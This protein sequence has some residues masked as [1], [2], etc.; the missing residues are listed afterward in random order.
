MTYKESLDTAFRYAD[1]E[2]SDFDYPD[3]FH[4]LANE[5]QMLIATQGDKILRECEVSTSSTASGPPSP[6][7]EGNGFEL[8]LPEDLYEIR[9]IVDQNGRP[10]EY[11]VYERGIAIVPKLGSYKVIYYALPEII[12]ENTADNYEYEVPLYTHVAIPYYIAY[13][14]VG[15]DDTTLYQALKN[16]WN[17]YMGIFN[18]TGKARVKKIVNVYGI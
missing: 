7:G 10:V 15:T 16:Q 18:Q 2:R 3:M 17:M 13:R 14:L 1:S 4:T 9:G 6:R 8:K 5:A 12:D 11:E